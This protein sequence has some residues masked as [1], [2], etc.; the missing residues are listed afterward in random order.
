MLSMMIHVAA[1]P[2]GDFNSGIYSKFIPYTPTINVTGIKS[3]EIMVST[4]ITSLSLL[5]KLDR[6][7]SM[8]PLMRSR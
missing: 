1:Y 3:V 5:L 7:R 8:M 6:Y 4:F 2:Y